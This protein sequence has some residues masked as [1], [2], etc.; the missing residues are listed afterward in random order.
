MDEVFDQVLADNAGEG[1]Y[2]IFIRC[3]AEGPNQGRTL[4]SGRMAADAKG[5]YALGLLSEGVYTFDRARD[6]TCP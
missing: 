5:A 6:A 3:G 4:A 2:M 1:G